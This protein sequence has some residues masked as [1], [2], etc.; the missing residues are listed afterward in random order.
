MRFLFLPALLVASAASAETEDCAALGLRSDYL[1]AMFCAELKSIGASVPT[2]RGMAGAETDGTGAQGLTEWPDF[3][4][5]Q[6]AYRADPRKTLEL[7][8]RIKEA[9]GLSSD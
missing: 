1:A 5:L 7:I 6:D 3:E 4:I 2:A 9:G 8:R